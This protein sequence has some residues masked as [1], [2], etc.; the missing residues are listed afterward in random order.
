MLHSGG[1]GQGRWSSWL[2]IL[3]PE[4][5]SPILTSTCETKKSLRLVIIYHYDLVKLNT[6]AGNGSSFTNVN[7]FVNFVKGLQS[8]AWLWNRMLFCM[9]WTG[10][11]WLYLGTESADN[12]IAKSKRLHDRTY[13]RPLTEKKEAVTQ[14]NIKISTVK[15]THPKR[16]ATKGSLNAVIR[17]LLHHFQHTIQPVMFWA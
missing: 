16:E 15:Q 12:G 17:L 2:F 9:T 8:L 11:I 10:V 3:L 14:H 6:K 7:S 4:L 5:A 13:E 1:R